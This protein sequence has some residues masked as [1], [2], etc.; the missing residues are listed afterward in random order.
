[1]LAREDL[2]RGHERR[3]PARFDGARH[4]QERDGGLAGADIALQEAEH[5]LVGD[6]VAADILDRAALGAGEG[7]RERLLDPSHQGAVAGVLASRQPAHAAAHE[8][9]GELRGEKLIVGEPA[10]ARIA[11]QGLFGHLSR[12]LR[13]M[14]GAEGVSYGR[15]AVPVEPGAV[16]PLGEAR[17]SLQGAAD[18]ARDQA[19]GQTLRL[20][21]DRLDGRQAGRLALVEDP[22][23]MDHLALAVP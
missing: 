10:P 20:A 5:A 18:E 17:Q 16:L 2:G 12:V 6:E 1:M 3:L 7:E 22:V 4:G 15:K 13:A 14:Q 23:R 8:G 11:G 19:R 21:V 9:E